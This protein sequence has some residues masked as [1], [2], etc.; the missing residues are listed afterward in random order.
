M[1]KMARVAAVA[2]DPR[3]F[4]ILLFACT[5]GA[6]ITAL[7]TSDWKRGAYWLASAARITCVAF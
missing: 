2:L 1:F 6:A 3:I 7:A 5:I 4:P